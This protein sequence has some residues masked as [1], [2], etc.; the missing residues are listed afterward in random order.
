MI[1]YIQSVG[2]I[3]VPFIIIAWGSYIV[4][5]GFQA[6]KLQGRLEENNKEEI[7]KALKAKIRKMCFLTFALVFGIFLWYNTFIPKRAVIAPIVSEKM[8]DVT[9]QHQ[10]KEELATDAETRK[11]PTGM[12]EKVGNEDALKK[13]EENNPYRKLLKEGE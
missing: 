8:D 10:T 4:W 3:L 7:K 11:D 2:N 1:S 13:A 9:A 6:T 12:I 5:V